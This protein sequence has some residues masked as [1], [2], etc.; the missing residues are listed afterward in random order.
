MSIPKNYAITN[1]AS[2]SASEILLGLFANP[3]PIATMPNCALYCYGPMIQLF[4]FFIM[5]NYQ[6]GKAYGANVQG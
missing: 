1:A 3:R 5:V 4:V 2:F 6:K